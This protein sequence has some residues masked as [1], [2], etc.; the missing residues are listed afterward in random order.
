MRF[1][2]D[3]NVCIDLI[4]RR[5]AKM[6]RKLK[7]MRPDDICV[8]SITL[9]ELEYGVAK[10]AAPE[11]NRLALAEFMTPLAIAAYD[12]N[13]APHYGRIRAELEARGTPIGPLDTMIAAHAVALG[14]TLVTNNER[15]FRRIAELTV[16]NWVK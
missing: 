13:V 2:F 5:S 7:R 15:E 4:R 12:D 3:T 14:L 1:M 8:S 11:K 6:L 16:E 9:S 10:S